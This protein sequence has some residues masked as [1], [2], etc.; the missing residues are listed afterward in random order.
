MFQLTEKE[1]ELLVS[2]NVIPSKQ[3]LGGYLPYVFTQEGLQ[4][5]PAY[6]AASEQYKLMLP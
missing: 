6:C 4:C 1:A 5:S 3:V 2:Q